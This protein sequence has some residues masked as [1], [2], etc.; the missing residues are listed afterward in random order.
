MAG[1][2]SKAAGKLENKFKYNG[3]ELQHQEFND[4]SGLEWYDYGARMYDNQ[5]GRW[6]TVDPKADLMRRWSPYNYAFDNPIRF[7]DPDGMGPTDW[8]A[9]KNADGTYTPQ[10]DKSIHNAGQANAK[11]AM[12]VGKTFNYGATDGKNYQL[13]ANGTASS[14]KLEASSAAANNTLSTETQAKPSTT[15]ATAASSEPAISKQS[16]DGLHK[17]LETTHTAIDVVDNTARLTIEKGF[18]TA[19]KISPAAVLEEGASAVKTSCRVLGAAGI[20]LSVIDA[21][22]D[23]NGP[24]LK[25]GI[26]VAVGVASFIPVAGEFIGVGWFVGNLVSLGVN[27]KSL[28]ENIQTVIDKK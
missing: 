23:P 18:E 13:N 8:I 11:G 28:S 3:K 9:Y 10:Y 22:T 2:S 6:M 26:D 15:T 12:Y 24:Q 19:N 5:I 4:G 20:A 1:I 16:S 21:A 25:H 14:T 17:G 27:G 7:I